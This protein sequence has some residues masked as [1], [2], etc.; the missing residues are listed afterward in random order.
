MDE[1]NNTRDFE[2][3]SDDAEVTIG[4]ASWFELSVR[5]PKIV[6]RFYT[7]DTNEADMKKISESPMSVISLEGLQI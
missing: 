7:I 1:V 6:V 4:A 5:L 2:L 3:D